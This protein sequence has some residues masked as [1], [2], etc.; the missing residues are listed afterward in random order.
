MRLTKRITALSRFISHS[1]KR[2]HKIFVALNKNKD[3]ERTLEYQQAPHDLK[4]YLSNLSL[5]SKPQLEEQ[6]LVYLAVS[7]IVVHVVLV[8]EDKGKKFLI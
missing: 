1:S 7:E 8:R 3:F 5:M 2:C 4:R 6:L